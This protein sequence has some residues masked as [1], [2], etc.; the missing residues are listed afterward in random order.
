MRVNIVRLE[1]AGRRYVVGDR[2]PSLILVPDEE[3]KPKEIECPAIVGAIFHV[4]T[5][6]NTELWS[7]EEPGRDGSPAKRVTYSEAFQDPQHY[8]IWAFPDEGS[9]LE[10][11]RETRV[12]RVRDGVVAE[13]TWPLE[14]AK[15]VVRGRRK[16]TEIEDGGDDDDNET[17]D[18]PIA[19]VA[20][21]S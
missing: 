17:D 19:P 12:L 6:T 2:W 10:A 3:G 14:A 16:A 8:E 15:S 4:Q 7:E 13:E 1:V 9:I 21:E 5:S 11:A 20:A 18:E